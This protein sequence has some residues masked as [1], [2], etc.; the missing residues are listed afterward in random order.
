MITELGMQNQDQFLQLFGLIIQWIN[1]QEL[2]RRHL[3]KELI[4]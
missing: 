3:S 2:E 4:P 1:T